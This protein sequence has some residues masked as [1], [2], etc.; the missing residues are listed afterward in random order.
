MHKVKKKFKEDKVVLLGTQKLALNVSWDA[1][2]GKEQMTGGLD[3]YNNHFDFEK[4]S[5]LNMMHSNA[6]NTN[7]TDLTNQ[8]IN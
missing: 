7:A 6:K 3:F 2:K 8:P 5:A 1:D 4:T